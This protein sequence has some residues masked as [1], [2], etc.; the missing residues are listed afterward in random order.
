MFGI[1]FSKFFD[2][3]GNGVKVEAVAGPRDPVA[4]KAAAAHSLR[5]NMWVTVPNGRTG[6]LTN[7]NAEGIATVMLTQSDGTNLAQVNTMLASL[8][9]ATRDEIP[10]GR[11][12]GRDRAD[13]FGYK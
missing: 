3:K 9:Q 1:D 4:K 7:A 6:I 13:Q 2:K 11:R 5:I 8:R 12:P 10:V